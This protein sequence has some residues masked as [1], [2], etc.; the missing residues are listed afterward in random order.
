MKPS[1]RLGITTLVLALALPMAALFM[2]VGLYSALL[3]SLYSLNDIWK[4]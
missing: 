3:G 4:D 1:H 2:L